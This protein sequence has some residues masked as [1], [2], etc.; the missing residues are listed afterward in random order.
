M[1]GVF[2]WGGQA[3]PTDSTH[4]ILCAT[5]VHTHP[6]QHLLQAQKVQT[7]RAQH[8]ICGRDIFVD[9]SP[10]EKVSSEGLLGHQLRTAE[11]SDDTKVV[12][13]GGGTKATRRKATRRTIGKCD[14]LG[15]CFEGLVHRFIKRSLKAE[16]TFFIVVHAEAT[17]GLPVQGTY[18]VRRVVSAGC[19]DL[20]L[21]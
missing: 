1:D 8:F 7:S 11:A 4:G 21:E 16:R 6:T 19:I 20:I 17:P 10:E 12:D 9:H 3:F 14:R 5:C 18:M 15:N 13:A 2:G